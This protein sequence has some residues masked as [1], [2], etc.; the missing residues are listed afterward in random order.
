M[1]ERDGYEIEPWRVSHRGPALGYVL[2]RARPAG[3]LRPGKAARRRASTEGPEFG[4]VQ[5]GETVDGVT[6]EQVMGP[7]RAR[8]QAHAL[9]R[10][11]PVRRAAR[12]RPP[13]RRADPR[14]DV[15]D[16][17]GR[18]R[19]TRPATRPRRRRPAIARDAEVKLLALNHFSIRYPARAHPRRG[20]RDLRQHGAAARLRH[21]RDPVRRARRARAAPLGRA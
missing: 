3:G 12:G 18:A 5:R 1:L 2:P 7:T 14:G 16:R 11:A 15:R 8:T 9:R 6:P 19:R 17:G 20:A 4:R 21:D 13:E 10:H